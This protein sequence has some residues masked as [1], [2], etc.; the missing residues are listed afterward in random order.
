MCAHSRCI[1]SRSSCAGH[2]RAERHLLDGHHRVEVGEPHRLDVEGRLLLVD[3]HLRRSTLSALRAP[4]Q[5]RLP[6]ARRPGR[7]RRSPPTACRRPRPSGPRPTAGPPTAGH[8]GTTPA[9]SRA[10]AALAR[11]QLVDLGEHDLRGDV[12]GAEP[13]VELPFLVF[14]PPARVDQDDEQRQ[15]AAGPR[16]AFDQRLPGAPLGLR[17]PRVAVAGQVDQAELVDGRRVRPGT[18]FPRRSEARTS[19]G[20]AS[21]PASWTCAPGPCAPR[22]GS[23]TSTCRR[24]T[25][26]RSRSPARPPAADRRD[27]A[28]RR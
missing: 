5:V 15:R 11:R 3:R 1:S 23:A 27:R 24:S 6:P 12:L 19:P 8:R 20:R 25:G 7:R 26:R 16:V 10:A 22:A 18:P 21:A 9:P 28:P 17:H 14:D 13:F 4:P 2:R